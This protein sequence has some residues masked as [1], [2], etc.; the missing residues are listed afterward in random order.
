[1]KLTVLYVLIAAVFL[2]FESCRDTGLPAFYVLEAH[3]PADGYGDIHGAPV[4]T[5]SGEETELAGNDL[6]PAGTYTKPDMQGARALC[7][8]SGTFGSTTGGM[9]CSFLNR[10]GTTGALDILSPKLLFFLFIAGI[11]SLARALERI[12]DRNR[13]MEK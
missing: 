8:T 11:G 4:E 3:S 7:K 5:D 2:C 12:N 1:M 13:N 10:F 6:A 9:Y